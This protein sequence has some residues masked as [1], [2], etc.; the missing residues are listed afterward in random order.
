MNGE[1]SAEVSV[2]DVIPEIGCEIALSLPDE[3]LKSKSNPT[4][5]TAQPA[6]I[7]T[8]V[9]LIFAFLLK[10]LCGPDSFITINVGSFLYLEIV[11]IDVQV[12]AGAAK[13]ETFFRLLV[14]K[15]L[16]AESVFGK[17]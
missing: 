16:A 3:T 8:V 10:Y 9:F 15:I 7:V 6:A 1:L 17:P 12:L 13:Y 14:L 11:P 4:A 2:S 5:N